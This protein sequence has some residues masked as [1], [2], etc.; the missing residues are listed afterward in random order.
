[1]HEYEGRSCCYVC[2]DMTSLDL[3][4]M[5]LKVKALRYVETSGNCLS[6]NTPRHTTVLESSGT[7]HL[8]NVT[9]LKRVLFSILS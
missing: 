2:A 5:S 1:M 4:C 7:A 6:K 9:N 3:N 8:A